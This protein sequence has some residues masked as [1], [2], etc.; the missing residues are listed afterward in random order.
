MG[1]WWNTTR[2]HLPVDVAAEQQSSEQSSVGPDEVDPAAVHR[3]TA[4]QNQNQ[5]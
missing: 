1:Q 5:Y 2:E 3:D 4:H